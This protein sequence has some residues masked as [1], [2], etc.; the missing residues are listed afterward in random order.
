MARHGGILVLAAAI[1]AAPPTLAAGDPETGK[2][3]ATAWCS[4]CHAVE[5]AGTDAAP[6]LSAIANRPGSSPD[7]L[8]GWLSDPHPPMPQLSLTRQEIADLI[9]YLQT[10][11]P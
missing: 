4:G 7:Y 3:L 1:L 6:P 9:A 11:R 5:T 8:F 2:A 10:L